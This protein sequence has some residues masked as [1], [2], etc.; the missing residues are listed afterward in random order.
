MKIWFLQDFLETFSASDS[1]SVEQGL[2]SRGGGFSHPYSFGFSGKP[3]QLVSE[4]MD[5][6]RISN[7]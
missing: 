7:N 5:V 6:N 4:K 2:A 3:L 1:D